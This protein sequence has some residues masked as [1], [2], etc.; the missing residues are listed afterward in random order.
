MVQGILLRCGGHVLVESQPG[1]GSRFELLFPIALPNESAPSPQ[2]DH[3]KVQS[4]W[5]QRIWVLDDEPAVARYL[6]ELLKDSGYSVRLFNEPFQVLAA[7]EIETNDVDLLITDQT[8]PGLSGVALALRL[9]S[10]RPNLP[11]ILC[12]GYSDG[13]ARA[14]VLRNGI[15]RYF[16]KPVPTDELIKAVAEELEQK[17]S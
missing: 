3:L 4:G 10:L 11:I 2:Q 8:M 15:R 14:E 1:R 16:I 9:H 12:T 13:I 5:G 17:K 7:F 6:G